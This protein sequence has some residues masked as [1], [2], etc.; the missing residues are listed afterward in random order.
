MI[1]ASPVPRSEKR[2]PALPSELSESLAPSTRRKRLMSYPAAFS[3]IAA[4]GVT[5]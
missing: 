2:G 5:M 4:L 1:R 3:A